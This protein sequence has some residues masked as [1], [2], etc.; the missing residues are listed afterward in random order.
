MCALA[1]GL[2]GAASNPGRAEKTGDGFHL[3]LLKRHE[4]RHLIVARLDRPPSV[5]EALEIGKAA[6]VPVGSDP[7]PGC[8]WLQAG[9][10]P[11]KRLATLEFTWRE[12]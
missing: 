2:D 12:A 8:K 4:A 6:G 10:L 7:R 3:V 1:A 11:A 5:D 9:D